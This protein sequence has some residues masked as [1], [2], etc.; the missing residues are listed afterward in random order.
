MYSSRQASVC[1]EVGNR[2]NS[3]LSR[4]QPGAERRNTRSTHRALSGDAQATLC[5]QVHQPI[6]SRS[7][8]ARPEG[9]ASGVC[10]TQSRG[11]R[12]SRPRPTDALAHRGATLWC[13]GFSLALPGGLYS[14][15]FQAVRGSRQPRLRW[16]K[17]GGSRAPGFGSAHEFQRLS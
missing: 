4:T 17:D 14:F 1:D 12:Q 5:L 8:R 13:V 9:G 10:V 3:W 16:R 15:T 7:V 11:R 6:P 2:N